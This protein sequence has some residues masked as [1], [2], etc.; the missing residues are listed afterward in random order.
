MNGRDGTAPREPDS[1]TPAGLSI[2]IVTA[3]WNRADTVADA[4]ASVRS[5]THPNV[6]H[7]VV[8]GASTDGTLDVLERLAGPR[9]H[10]VSEPDTGIYD[11]LNKGLARAR[12]DIVGLLHSDDVF[13][14]ERV[15]ELVME[16]FADPA[17]DAVYGD[18]AVVSSTDIAR[19]MRYW[20]AGA[21]APHSL[22]RGWMPPHP[23]L[24]F[25]RSLL[26]AHGDFDTTFRIAADYDL[27]LRWFGRG[28]IRAAYV[29]EVLVRMRLGGASNKSFAQMARKSRED[30]RAL[31]NNAGAAS[32]PSGPV[33]RAATLAAKNLVKL[34]QFIHNYRQPPPDGTS[35][36]G[37]T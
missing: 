14:H 35:R 5:Q 7:V 2:S 8:D 24:F 34:P 10:V 22:R 29:P 21:Q 18:M 25:R 16:R 3:V 13:A 4:L 37:G 9:T 28:G 32:L 27:I 19:T 12:G 26:E 30:W 6:E 17:V 15:V 1:T 33:G 36:G 11:A 31:A 23:T 20:V